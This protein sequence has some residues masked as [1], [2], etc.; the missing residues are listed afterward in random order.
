MQWASAVHCETL[1]RNNIQTISA[2]YG[3]QSQCKGVEMR[4]LRVLIYGAM[5]GI[6]A[7]IP[8]SAQEPLLTN[9]V[10]EL[11]AAPDDTAT[12]VKLLAEKAPVQLQERKGAWSRVKSA[13]DTGWVRMM[14]LRGGTTIASDQ[15]SSGGGWL[16]SMN[17]LLSA[18][19]SRTNQRAQSATVGIR[20]F[21]KDDLAQAELNPAEFAKLKRYQ[22]SS[23]DAQ[24]LA[25][26]GSLSF[27]SVAYLAQD[28]VDGANAAGA[29]K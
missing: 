22:A 21:S 3:R 8:A 20:G 27:R 16:A 9:R 13:N 26:Q 29:K 19:D 23:A 10:T 28:A 2:Q 12:V 5:L 4:Q 6:S 14:H 24:Q 18:S 11:R 1:M 7:M 17:R 15:Q 25:G